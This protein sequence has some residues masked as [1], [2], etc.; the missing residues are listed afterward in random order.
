MI[1]QLQDFQLCSGFQL[2]ACSAQTF[3]PL[4][5]KLSCL[6]RM[7]PQGGDRHVPLSHQGTAVP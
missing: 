4:P 7:F 3:V 1:T 2:C 6:T 5:S